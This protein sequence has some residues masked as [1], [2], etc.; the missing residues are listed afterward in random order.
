M[1][2]QIHK[3]YLETPGPECHIQPHP[4]R[5][6]GGAANIF[7]SSAD[8]GYWNG[9]VAGCMRQNGGRRTLVTHSSYIIAETDVKRICPLPGM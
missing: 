7:Q 2:K 1:N 6:H 8:I 5:E 9:Q 4:H 3:I